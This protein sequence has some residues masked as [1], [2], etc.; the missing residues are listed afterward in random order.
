M[1]VSACKILSGIVALTEWGLSINEFGDF[2][3]IFWF[4]GII[5]RRNVCQHY[6]RPTI[7]NHFFPGRDR[8]FVCQWM[9]LRC[10]DRHFICQSMNLSSLTDFLSVSERNSLPDRH[11][12][13]QWMNLRYWQTFCLSVDE[14]HCL[15]DILSVSGRNS[16]PDRHFVCQWT[17][18]IVWQTFCL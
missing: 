16:L 15:T 17:K 10:T 11:F 4:F 14:I 3:Q 2:S 9:N 7:Y 5:D 18:F 6:E 12:V 1:S 8:R 13:C